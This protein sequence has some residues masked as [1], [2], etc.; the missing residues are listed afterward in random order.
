MSTSTSTT[1]MTPSVER[2]HLVS[3]LVTAFSADPFIRWF[4]P[5]STSYLTH[6][7]EIAS[8]YVATAERFD[9]N[10]MAGDGAGAAVWVAPGT[11]VDDEAV[12]RVLE[13]SVDRRRLDGAS[14]LV[15]A[16]DAHRP[17][18][19]VWYLPLI[20][21]DP[22]WQGRSLG[23]ALLER[24]LAR[25]DADSAPAYL[26]ATTPRNRS[27]YER[28]GFRATGEIQVADSPTIWPMLR[29]AT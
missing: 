2:N 3:I 15:E 10:D 5:A 18:G 27:L 9:T 4:F 16:M 12:G 6:F 29:P 22:L 8:L 20:G 28:H 21:V 19:P 23:S 24:G 17:D 13:R 7:P 25:A 11:A 26:D 14:R 1:T